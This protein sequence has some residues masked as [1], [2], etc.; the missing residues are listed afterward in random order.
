MAIDASP[1]RSDRVSYSIE[2]RIHL[3]TPRHSGYARA[4][5]CLF[6]LWSHGL[7]PNGPLPLHP[8]ASLSFTNASNSRAQVGCSDCKLRVGRSQSID[9]W[10]SPCALTDSMDM[11]KLPRVLPVNAFV[12]KGAWVYGGLHVERI[13][14]GITM[15]QLGADQKTLSRPGR[16]WRPAA[17][18]SLY[19]KHVRA[20]GGPVACACSSRRP[21]AGQRT[22]ERQEPFTTHRG[23]PSTSRKAPDRITTW[24]PAG[25]L[26]RRRSVRGDTLPVC[27]SCARAAGPLA[28]KIDIPGVRS[29]VV[30]HAIQVLFHRH[31][32]AEQPSGTDPGRSREASDLIL[33]RVIPPAPT[34]MMV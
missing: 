13:L 27:G 11:L 1:H 33:N 9:T 8:A 28:L 12:R 29:V 30:L 4:P 16:A 26:G 5:G 23:G 19:P 6:G 32:D 24:S 21:R 20:G 17:R 15:D 14:K 3:A 7:G 31:H 10:T 18:R 22:D 25:H 2:P 34:A